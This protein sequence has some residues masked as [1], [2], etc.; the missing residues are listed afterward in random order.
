[1]DSD[2][3]G[4]Y[5]PQNLGAMRR[6]GLRTIWRSCQ[7]QS[8]FSSLVDGRDSGEGLGPQDP[9]VDILPRMGPTLD[10][11]FLGHITYLRSSLCRLRR[12]GR[13]NEERQ[14]LQKLTAISI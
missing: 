10:T 13:T 6:G 3:L 14:G 1:M 12:L 7:N 4:G 2:V 9:S 8:P 11:S 5:A